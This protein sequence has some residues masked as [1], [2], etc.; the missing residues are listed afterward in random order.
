[1]NL[2]TTK[3]WIYYFIFNG[4]VIDMSQEVNIGAEKYW[5]FYHIAEMKFD[6]CDSYFAEIENFLLKVL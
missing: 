6:M 4:L 3:V 1:M 5:S 2:S